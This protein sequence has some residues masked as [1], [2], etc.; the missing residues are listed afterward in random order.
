MIKLCQADKEKK[1]AILEQAKQRE[2]G[3]KGEAEQGRILQRL[4]GSSLN[5]AMGAVFGSSDE[6]CDFN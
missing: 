4:K 2:L 5:N 3:E 6:T 1:T